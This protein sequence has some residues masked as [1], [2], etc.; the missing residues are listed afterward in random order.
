MPAKDRAKA[1]ERARPGKRGPATRRARRAPFP[2]P[3]GWKLDRGGKSVS[4]RL[5]T[6]DFLDAVAHI[7]R[8]ASLAEE[9]EH[10]PDLHLERWNRLRVTTYSHDAG[11]LTERDERLA[12]AITEL[13]ARHGARPD[14]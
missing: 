13:L 11:R 5:T 9:L 8:I 12:R 3:E 1:R 14:A 7:N 6:R 2:L 4:L 10:H